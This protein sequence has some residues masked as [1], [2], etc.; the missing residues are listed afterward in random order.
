MAR[1]YYDSGELEPN[2]Q[3]EEGIRNTLKD[4]SV[5]T[6]EPDH[7]AKCY[8]LLDENL[9]ITGGDLLAKCMAIC[10]AIDAECEVK[11]GK[12]HFRKPRGK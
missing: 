2:A 4:H 5:A 9:E 8:D 6:A 10:K 7:I 11:N 1:V 12:V 3:I